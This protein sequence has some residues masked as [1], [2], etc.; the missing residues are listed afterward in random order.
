MSEH[1]HLINNKNIVNF[2]AGLLI[3]ICDYL[4]SSRYSEDEAQRLSI[5][6]QHAVRFKSQR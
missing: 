2:T 4:Q 5:I 6:F 3:D 1:P